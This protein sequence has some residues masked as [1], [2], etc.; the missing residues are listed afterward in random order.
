MGMGAV[1]PLTHPTRAVT[2]QVR[3]APDS[4]RP[5][6][7]SNTTAPWGLPRRQGEPGKGVGCGVLLMQV[8]VVGAPRILQEPRKGDS[9]ALPSQRLPGLSQTLLFRSHHAKD[10]W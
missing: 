7:H 6:R 4:N 1:V 8:Q 5:E 10:P 9:N 3:C 2:T